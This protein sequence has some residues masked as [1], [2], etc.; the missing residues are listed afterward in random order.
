MMPALLLLWYGLCF[1]L[2][3]SVFCRSV[4]AS[5]TTKIDVRLAL[6]GVG[7]AALGGMAAP[8]YGWRPDWVDLYLVGAFVLMQFVMARHWM[9]AVPAQYVKEAYRQTAPAS[10]ITTETNQP[11]TGD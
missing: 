6:W 1:G 10:T 4:R 7:A 2:F 8:V 5:H 11:T 9:H 3:W